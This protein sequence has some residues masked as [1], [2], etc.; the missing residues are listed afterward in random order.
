[1]CGD[2]HIVVG[3]GPWLLKCQD[4]LRQHGLRRQ[5]EAA[6]ATAVEPL[7]LRL[8]GGLVVRLRHVDI[9][10]EG[11]PGILDEGGGDGTGIDGDDLDR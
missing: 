6:A 5:L 3:A 2:G 7:A 8:E 9:G 4:E 11:D 1:M 10:F